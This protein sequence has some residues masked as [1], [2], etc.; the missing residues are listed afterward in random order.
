MA[1]PRFIFRSLVGCAVIHR[2]LR[3][4]V[5]HTAE[6]PAFYRV[7]VDA[8]GNRSYS[9]EEQEKRFRLS[10]HIFNLWTMRD[11]VAVGVEPYRVRTYGS[12]W[13]C[14]VL[15]QGQAL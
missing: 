2:L 4:L 14:T 3:D 1:S 11:R 12:L 15:D 6:S 13:A 10:S 5:A 9:T 7:G 8:G